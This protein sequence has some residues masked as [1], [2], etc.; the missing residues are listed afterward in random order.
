MEHVESEAPPLT[1]EQRELGAIIREAVADHT[2]PPAG[3]DDAPG[4]FDRPLWDLLARQIGVAALAVPERFGGAGAGHLECH[5]VLHELGRAAV[6]SPFLATAVLAANAVLIADDE[7]AAKEVLPPLASGEA[8]A[9]VVWD[10]PLTAAAGPEGA[11]WRVDGVADHVLDGARAEVLLAVAGTPQGPGL[12]WLDTTDP[13]LR[14]EAAATVD[15]SLHLAAVRC[16]GVKARRIGSSA[17]AERAAVR[18]ADLAAAA[19]TADQVGGAER[20]LELTVEYVSTRVQF[21]RPIGSFQAIK[22]RL[23]D[24]FVLVESARSA[25]LAA[26]AAWDRDAPDAPLLASLAKSYC[27]EAYRTVA[28]ETIQLHGGIGFTWEHPAHR[29]FKRAHA[30]AALFGDPS[31]HRRRLANR[32]GLT[33]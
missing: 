21:G 7:P 11:G 28:A 16:S 33:P 4:A 32:L 22:H 29:Y 9:A 17:G 31:H 19:V 18:L 26:A 2:V 14:R 13:G 27:S 23:A 15:Q 10:A 3:P 25:S 12:F 24:L 8:T 20:C 1:E 30:T 5:V 6:A